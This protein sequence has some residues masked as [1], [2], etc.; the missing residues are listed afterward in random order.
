MGY[1]KMT[2]PLRVQSSGVVLRGEGMGDTGTVLIGTGNSRT[3]SGPG[4]GQPTLLRIAG[5]SGWTTRD[6]TKQSVLD[7]Y[8]PVGARG[9]KVASARDFR[10]GDKVIVRRIGNQDWINAVG[11]NGGARRA[12]GDRS[13]SIG[14][15]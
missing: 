2:T 11:M 14:I 4:A 15:A 3:A 10:P 9:F 8:V 7:D 5:A 13:T 6:E 12:A 1:Y